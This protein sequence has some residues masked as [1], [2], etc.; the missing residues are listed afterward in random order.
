MMASKDESFQKAR[1][2]L[3]S[4]GPKYDPV[5]FYRSRIGAM[6]E[7]FQGIIFT[8]S[9]TPID[10]E[11][12]GFRI[13]TK[14]HRTNK[15][16]E[17]ATFLIA[18]RKLCRTVRD[19]R[20]DLVI[21][22]DPLKS[23]LLGI[24]AAKLL[25]AKL[26]VE[27]NGLYAVL[28]NYADV[29][30]LF[31]RRLKR[32]LYSRVQQFVLNRAHGIKILFPAQ[33]DDLKIQIKNK[34]VGVFANFVDIAPFVTLPMESSTENHEILFVGFP[35]YLKGV[36]L[37][38]DAFR[39]VS[40]NHP[41]WTLK[42]LGWYRDPSLINRAIDGHPRI[43]YHRAVPHGEMPLHLGHC[44][45]LVLPSRSEAMGR[46]L[47][48]AMAAGKPRIGTDV[49]GIP[50][51][52]S[53]GQDGLL[54]EKDQVDDLAA[55]LERL[56]DDAA[57]RRRLGLNGRNRAVAEFTPEVYRRNVVDFYTRCIADGRVRS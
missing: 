52:I 18:L 50:A 16:T 47:V 37:L 6:K 29:R 3:I 13:I 57:E 33:I 11:I 24:A 30:S 23:G 31:R 22:Y 5:D 41:E 56:M 12:D 36:D 55:A 32:W 53:H 35:H 40:V 14:R 9:P 51:V 25:R 38:I 19:S 28:D 20:I 44:S 4:P 10:M 17:F 42:I 45:I 7:S 43:S 48:E 34:V 26:V 54:F 49:G 2:L 27:V 21:T 15:L 1:L 8:S 46:I 39:K